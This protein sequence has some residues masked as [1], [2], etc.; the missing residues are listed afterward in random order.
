MS[1]EILGAYRGVALVGWMERDHAV[2]F[3]REDCVFD[4]PLTDAGAESLWA[5]YR[6]RAAGL[7]MRDVRPPSRLP[8]TPAE[9]EHSQRFLRFVAG[10]GVNNLEVLKLDPMRLIVAQSH[11]ATDLA[12]NYTSRCPNDADW[13]EV[14]LPTSSTP[15]D[16]DIRFTRRNFDTEIL[17]D[18]PHGEFIFGLQPNGS[19]GPREFVAHT[20][21]VAA[22]NRMILSKGYHRLYARM[23]GTRLTPA[24]RSVLVALE[25]NA[26]VPGPRNIAETFGVFGSNPP[27]FSDFFTEGQFLRVNL[28]KKRYQLRVTAN[29]VAL[30][31]AS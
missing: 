11:V 18:L 22:G 28:R 31:D 23:A 9:H 25:P 10:I 4:P 5:E 3:L 1:T 6:N 17:I 26:F 21:V 19:F 29:W 12:Q 27:L 20:S 16:V 7:A 15:P 13:M 2:R 24:A 14:T 30:N 8:L